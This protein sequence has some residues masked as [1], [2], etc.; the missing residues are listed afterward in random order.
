M[1]NTVKGII[2]ILILIVI[3]IKSPGLFLALV[4]MAFVLSLIVLFHEFGHYI[5]AKKS[6]ILVREFSLGF[7]PLLFGKQSGDTLYC[8][9][10]IPLGGYVDL[11]GMDEN[12]ELED[13]SKAF[14]SKNPWIKMLVLF[15]GSFMNFVLAFFIYWLINSGYGIPQKPY[16]LMPVV[17]SAI[18]DTPAYEI[19]L[20]QGDMIIAIDTLEVNDYE[21]FRKFVQT[22]ASEEVNL[23]IK[24][25]QEMLSFKV[26]PKRHETTGKGYLGIMPDTTNCI[27]DVMPETP[28]FKAKFKANDQ[29]LKI[30][31]EKI[32]YFSQISDAMKKYED[33]TV[34]ILIHRDTIE[35]TIAARVEMPDHFGFF[36]PNMAL[37]GDVMSSLPA[38]T[39][40]M[41]PGDKVVK[42]NGEDIYTWGQMLNVVKVNAKKELLFT[43]LREEKDAVSG[44]LIK[45]SVE[46]KITPKF[47]QASGEGRIG[48]TLRTFQGERLGIVDGAISALNQVTAITTEMINGIKK[49]VL[50]AISTEY[51]QGPVGIANIVKDQA[52]EGIFQLLNIT[53]LISINI[54]LLNL[55]PIPGL[56]GGRIIFTFLEAVRRRRLSTKVEEGIHAVGIVLLILLAILVTY[57]DI[58]RLMHWS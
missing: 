37:I 25:G 9:R 56:D 27:G 18:K 34:E 19:G 8:V 51:I 24:R 52:K 10:P 35:M 41:K 12:D 45:K 44:N 55:F 1:S 26:T 28:A 58:L 30:G 15:A 14:Y 46:L 47:D 22:K 23:K 36:P 48:V 49:L 42:I 20:K 38:E 5:T 50:G 43:V 21:V 13:K 6:G 54:G 57:K 31:D 3:M 2:T 11:A 29:I 17:S 16:Y 32:E 7:G 39:G 53:A 4:S 40:G 33:K